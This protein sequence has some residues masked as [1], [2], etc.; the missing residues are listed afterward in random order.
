M[1]ELYSTAAHVAIQWALFCDG[2]PGE[3]WRLFY[4]AAS[5][6]SCARALLQ[7]EYSAC[8]A[9]AG[10][11]RR[12]GSATDRVQRVRRV[13]GHLPPLGRRGRPPAAGCASLRLLRRHCCC[14]SGTGPAGRT[15]KAHPWQHT[16]RG[17]QR[18]Q[19]QSWRY[20]AQPGVSTGGTQHSQGLAQAAHSTASGQHRRHTAEPGVSTEHPAPPVGMFIRQ[21]EQVPGYHGGSPQPERRPFPQFGTKGIPGG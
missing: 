3:L 20:T 6:L 16:A 9:S 12:T 11:Y 1:T 15:Q 14:C 8:G 2:V 19:N 13:C 5:T 10:I 4:S 18:S 17:Q 21:V 7:T